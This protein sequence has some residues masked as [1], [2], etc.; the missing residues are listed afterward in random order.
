VKKVCEVDGQ[1]EA[2]C[3]LRISCETVLY[4]QGS[5]N[6]KMPALEAL[7]AEV[8]AAAHAKGID[9]LHAA[10]FPA[11]ARKFRNF[12]DALGWSKDKPN[13]LWSRRTR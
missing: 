10:V 8:L 13:E 2:V 6:G 3:I 9:D 12:L 1:V 7:Q 4:C 11:V 5:P